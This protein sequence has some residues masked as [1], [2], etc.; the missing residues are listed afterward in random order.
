MWYLYSKVY[1]ARKKR[2]GD[3]YAIKMLKKDDMIRKNMVQ[4]VMAERDI[5][6]SV[7]NPFVVKLYYSF[8]SQ[9]LLKMVPNCLVCGSHSLSLSYDVDTEISISG[10]GIS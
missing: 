5:M 6:A 1:L 9:V 7:Q 8:Q 4:H 2:T 3:I 10:D